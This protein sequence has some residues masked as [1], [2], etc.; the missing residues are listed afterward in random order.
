MRCLVAVQQTCRTAAETILHY[1]FEILMKSR[2]IFRERLF[3]PTNISA[4][5]HH[6]SVPWEKRGLDTLF[7]AN[8]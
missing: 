5:A 6:A 4:R 1:S 7:F 2:R 8:A 3:V